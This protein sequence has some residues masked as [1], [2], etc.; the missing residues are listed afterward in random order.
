M[1]KVC[2]CFTYSPELQ[3][4]P[5]YQVSPF[6]SLTWL[7]FW[8]RWRHCDAIFSHWQVS[9]FSDTFQIS[10]SSLTLSCGSTPLLIRWYFDAPILRYFDSLLII[11]VESLILGLLAFQIPN[12]EP[13]LWL[14]C[15]LSALWLPISSALHLA[16]L[17]TYFTAEPFSLSKNLTDR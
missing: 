2:N 15:S 11:A 8:K 10:Y 6:V 4:P 16:G 14:G 1:K 9:S 13:E 7:C 12:N 17:K 3:G 5:R